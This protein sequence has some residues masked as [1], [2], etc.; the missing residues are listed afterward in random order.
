MTNYRGIKRVLDVVFASVLALT[1]FPLVLLISVAALVFH[2]RPIFF[3][4]VRPG[5]HEKPFKIVKFRTMA[6]QSRSGHNASPALTWFGRLLRY[7]SLDEL[8]QLLNILRGE[9]SFVGPRPLLIE[10]LPLYNDNQALRHTVRP[11]LTGLAQ[12]S[13]RN[14]L[15]WS[16][17]FEL[18]TRY[19]RELS[20]KLD[21]WIFLKTLRLVVFQTG[22]APSKGEIPEKFAG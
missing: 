3:L 9:M 22:V 11:G 12:V 4:Q 13:G 1:S 7:T 10:Y 20:F 21:L 8:P 14:T 5:L 15:S 19:A 2:G 18:D 16:E 6:R 17:K